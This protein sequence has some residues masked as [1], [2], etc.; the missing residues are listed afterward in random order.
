[1][2]ET[3]GFWDGVGWTAIAV[4]LIGLV[5]ILVSEWLKIKDKLHDL[6][7][8]YDMDFIYLKTRIRNLEQRLES[9]KDIFDVKG[10]SEIDS[11][12][13]RLEDDLK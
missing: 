5:Y 2:F 10:S 12:K 6:K 11:L 3:L 1:M 4:A 13:E 8:T 9:V 7:V